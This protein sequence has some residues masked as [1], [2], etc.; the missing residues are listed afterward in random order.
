MFVR[1]RFSPWNTDI[2]LGAAKKNT[3]Y[4]VSGVFILFYGDQ[5][6]MKRSGKQAEVAAAAA[7]TPATAATEKR[8]GKREEECAR[9]RSVIIERGSLLS[10]SPTAL[11][12]QLCNTFFAPF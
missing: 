7:P 9:H 3:F 2:A 6:M 1:S 11:S 12:V 4:N 5:E 8:N 10:Y